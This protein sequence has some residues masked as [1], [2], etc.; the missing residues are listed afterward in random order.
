MRMFAAKFLGSCA[1]LGYFPFAPGTITSLAAVTLFV[2]FPSLLQIETAL[3]VLAILFAS[4][5]WASGVME[6]VYGHDPSRVTIDEFAGQWLALLLLPV[7]WFTA[8]LGFVAFRFFDI[9]KPE[10]VNS[11]QKLPGGW[12]VMADDLLAGV[13]AN[14]SVRI[15]L[16]LLSFFPGAVPL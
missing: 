7:G 2:L 16:W 11:A 9:L 5:L 6:E 12:G 14:L 10:P 4:G 1:G 3:P 15:M 13:Y 8:I